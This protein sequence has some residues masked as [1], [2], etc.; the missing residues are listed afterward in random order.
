MHSAPID[1]NSQEHISLLP[2]LWRSRADL[3]LLLILLFSAGLYVVLMVKDTIPLGGLVVICVLWLLYRLASGRQFVKTP[4]DFPVLGLLALLPLSLFIS[5]DLDLTLPKVYGLILGVVFFYFIVHYIN[6]QKRLTMAIIFLV[7][8]P[9]GIVLMAAVSSDWS[10][11]KFAFLNQLF[12]HLPFL[13]KFIPVSIYERGINLNTIS[14]ALTFFVPFLI[15][16]LMHPRFVYLSNI[17]R[18]TKKKIWRSIFLFVKIISLSLVLLTLFLA[19]S[20]GAWLGITLGTLVLLVWKDR[21][22]L[23]LIPISIIGFVILLQLLSVKNIADVVNLFNINEMATLSDRLDI[24]RGAIYLIQDFPITGSGLGTYGRMF[25]R[26]YSYY[27]NVSFHAHNIFLTVAVDQGIPALILYTAMLSGF[28]CMGF[29]TIKDSERHIQ[30]LVVGIGCGMLS[31]HIFGIMDSYMLG[32]KMGVIMWI[33][34]GLMTALFIHN[35]NITFPLLREDANINREI[36][37]DHNSLPKEQQ[38]KLFIIGMSVWLLSCLVAIAFITNF[39]YIS[40]ILAMIG[41]ILLGFI[42][43]RRINVLCF[44]NKNKECYNQ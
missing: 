4:M 10:D 24:W 1:Q 41:G 34:L 21:R 9:I 44:L 19:R 40:L 38:V 36:P 42:I 37:G 8:L 43:S 18:G 15:S 5:I 29:F 35:H 11:S 22:F 33:Y 12:E 2:R 7:L 30:A 3:I 27:G 31:Y 6:N 23:W 13:S 26:F 25:T 14:G 16:L 17:K 32:S 39:P 20:R 28:T